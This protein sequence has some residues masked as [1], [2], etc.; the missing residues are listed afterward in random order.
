MEQLFIRK[1]SQITEQILS[2]SVAFSAARHE[3]DQHLIKSQKMGSPRYEG[4]VLNALAILASAEGNSA[5]EIRAF[6]A[7]REKALEADDAALFI[8]TSGNVATTYTTRWELDNAQT[9]LQSAVEYLE[10]HQVP[11]LLVLYTYL[12]LTRLAVRRCTFD[13][14]Q[15]YHDRA[16]TQVENIRLDDYS[17][18]QYFQAVIRLR[19]YQAMIDMMNANC[20]PIPKAIRLAEEQIRTT[21]R[22]DLLHENRLVQLLYALVCDQNTE[23]AQTVE[24][25]F[26]TLT[27]EDKLLLSILL[28]HA[29]LPEH[30]QRYSKQVLAGTDAINAEMREI[31]QRIVQ[32]DA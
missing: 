11:M 24:A 28:D 13:Q 23:R 1:V 19:H 12:N 15:Q 22:D 3:L 16:W 2:R 27:N 7:A 4:E 20:T 30:A 10:Q 8:K 25:A 31:A 14:A 17:Q 21:Q 6:Q 18:V 5:E 9:M 29:G 26:E 32:R